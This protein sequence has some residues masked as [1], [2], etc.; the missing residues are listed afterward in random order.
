M[1]KTQLALAAIAVVALGGVLKV[2]YDDGT[3]V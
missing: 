1:N 2:R 3:V